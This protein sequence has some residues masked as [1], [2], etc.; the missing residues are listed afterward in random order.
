MICGP[1]AFLPYNVVVNSFKGINDHLYEFIRKNLLNVQLLHHKDFQ[2][3]VAKVII[4]LQRL[5]LE[6]HNAVDL[7]SVSVLVCFT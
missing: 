2:K 5:S 3:S 4:R 1:V 7:F 6:S